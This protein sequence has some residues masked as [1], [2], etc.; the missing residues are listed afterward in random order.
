MKTR[1]GVN[2]K[3]NQDDNRNKPVGFVLA[4]PVVV[5]ASLVGRADLLA[6]FCSNLGC[7]LGANPLLLLAVPTSSKN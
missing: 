7:V 3:E 4:K 1:I 5:N 2:G 6:A